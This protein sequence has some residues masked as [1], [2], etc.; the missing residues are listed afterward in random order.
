M[1]QFYNSTAALIKF[2]VSAKK[3]P[4]KNWVNARKHVSA[5]VEQ[6]PQLV[7]KVLNLNLRAFQRPYRER[8][9]I[10]VT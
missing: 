3:K 6:V 5:G 4:S 1:N 10:V 9:K 7:L 2:R 8:K